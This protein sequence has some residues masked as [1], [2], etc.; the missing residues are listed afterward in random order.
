MISFVYALIVALAC[1][2][3]ILYGFFAGKK[4]PIIF[5]LIMPLCIGSPIITF[6][7]GAAGAITAYDITSGF[8]F[9]CLMLGLHH[10]WKR[11]TPPNWYMY[12]KI[13]L[14][15]AIFEITFDV[16]YYASMNLDSSA[17]MNNV[18]IGIE[19]PIYFLMIPF[20]ICKLICLGAVAFFFC[21][22]EFTKDETKTA[23][24]IVIFSL[25]IFAIGIILDNAEVY[26]LGLSGSADS[27]FK[28]SRVFGLDRLAQGRLMLLAI[29]LSLYKVFQNPTSLWTLAFLLFTSGLLYSKSRAA[30]LGLLV[31]L[32]AYWFFTQGKATV[33]FVFLAILTIPVYYYL[34]V[35][36][37]QS[38]ILERYSRM[39][40]SYEYHKVGKRPEIWKNSLDIIQEHP[41]ILLTGV[42][43]FNFSYGI[44]S[45]ERIA[46]HAHNDWL[47]C[48]LETGIFGLAFFILSVYAIFR[49]LHY[50]CR[51]EILEK[52]YLSQALISYLVAMLFCSFF[53]TSLF[54]SISALS[55]TAYNICI[56]SIATSDSW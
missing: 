46:E 20:Y 7:R 14:L 31:M 51:S 38:Q 39:T 28:D 47:T 11:T 10:K 56:F 29:A 13:F 37:E 45:Q 52:R 8:L 4:I 50:Q 32:L 54:P 24:N 5:G 3:L 16:P 6:T 42:G 18:H 23:K 12:A 9:I 55:M 33:L 1:C 26:N 34:F 43:Q 49:Q 53:E 41:L 48:L 44:S 27:S 22:I 17:L 40:T 30:F 19:I 15:I 36:Q 2:C 25:F 21:S 35:V